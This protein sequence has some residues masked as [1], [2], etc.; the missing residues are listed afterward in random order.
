MARDGGAVPQPPLEPQPAVAA[1]APALP[2]GQEPLVG[3]WSA[4]L[5]GLLAAL[6]AW[7]WYGGSG[8]RGTKDAEAAGPPQSS[9]RGPCQPES[10]SED[11]PGVTEPLLERSS[12]WIILE[13]KAN[14]VSSPKE[15]AVN[16]ATTPRE[17]NE[18][19]LQHSGG[20]GEPLETQLLIKGT[21][22]P[23][24]NYSEFLKNELH[25]PSTAESGLSKSQ[26]AEARSENT[27]EAPV[28]SDLPEEKCQEP[29]CP[30]MK[31][32][33]LVD[34]EE[35]EAVSELLAQGDANN[36]SNADGMDTRVSQDHRELEQ[37]DLLEADARAKRVVAVSPMPQPVQVTFRV[38]Y[39][40]H[41]AAQVIA[42][43][44]DHEC[45]GQ[46][47]HYVPLRCDKDW[48]WSDSITLPT[49]TR[50]EWKFILVENGKVRRWEECDN[51]TLVT[52]H[53]DK[54]AHEWW[55]YH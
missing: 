33:D 5:L 3:L 22:S 26:A 15:L 25:G 54:V 31:C 28:S 14:D 50:T 40:T 52:E 45:L 39:I 27:T 2:E 37:G 46:W 51:R 9:N 7:F 8:E 21:D 30:T 53:E 24:M 6:L 42:V 4:L 19:L 55:G 11:G 13:T 44:G 48:F 36:S 17:E 20:S 12:E 35:W 29:L 34:H 18:I 49:D 32:P 41:S 10:P 43:T 38:H 47:H 23:L 16:L 1:A